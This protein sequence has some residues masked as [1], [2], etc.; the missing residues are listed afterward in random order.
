M[1]SVR[2]TVLPLASVA[3]N[4]ASRDAFTF[5][6]ILFRTKSQ[7]RRGRQLHRRRALRAE[8][9]LVDRAVRVAFDL[10]QLHG[11][12]GVLAGIRDQRAADRAV[13]ADRMRFLGP[14]DAEVLLDLG[15]FGDSDVE[16]KSRCRQG[17]G[18]RNSNL[19]EIPTC[20]GRY[21]SQAS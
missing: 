19:Q 13:R 9:A 11:A 8:P 4:V 18:T 5:W 10:Q 16:A 15:R 3:T 7:A 6:A 2:L 20:D 1:P 21:S 14:R 17:P 12:I